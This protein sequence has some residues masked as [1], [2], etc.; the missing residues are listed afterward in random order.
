MDLEHWRHYHES[1]ALSTCPTAPDGGYD[2][3]IKHSWFDF[4]AN[5][6]EKSH[7]V[8]IATGNGAVAVIAVEASIKNHLSLH[9]SG[10]DLA[11]IDPVKFVPFHKSMLQHIN[12]YP[13]V[14]SEKLPFQQESVDAITAQYGLEY[15]SIAECLD[16]FKRILK[17]H[18]VC[19][20]IMHHAESELAKRAAGSIYESELV[21][22][23]D[24]VLDLTDK[25]FSVDFTAG[26][27]IKKK[28]LVAVQKLQAVLADQKKAGHGFLLSG[29]LDTVAYLVQQHDQQKK[30]P[31]DTMSQF[32]AQINL[33]IT[34][35]NDL[36]TRAKS[37]EQM[38][39]IEHLASARGFTT[40]SL[41]PIY[42]RQVNLIGWL[43]QL[44][45]ST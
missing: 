8:D 18:G 16:E 20:F 22:A 32:R 12:F 40:I 6:P 31:A 37:M 26:A 4:F 39:E 35:L 17:P 10:T 1:G 7:I 45:K 11:N 27:A 14:S 25:L 34:R 3:E 2:G 33:S 42:H 36:L 19:Q 21:L 9:V 5:L 30:I 41:A 44:K 13:G 24:S 29:V 15:S 28:L 43:W 23:K 38:Q